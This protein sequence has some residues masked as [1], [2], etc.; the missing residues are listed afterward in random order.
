MGAESLRVAV[1]QQQLP[2]AFM[3][4]RRRAAAGQSQ[5]AVDLAEGF[6]TRFPKDPD[7][8]RN[9]LTAA[10]M[11]A[12]RFGRVAEA[13]HLLEG[14]QEKYPEH[15]LAPDI[16]LALAEVARMPATR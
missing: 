5:L 7:I 9:L 2:I 13:R 4:R 8:P 3:D 12:E 11:M 1:G 14:L 6:N 10:R 15:P 16:T